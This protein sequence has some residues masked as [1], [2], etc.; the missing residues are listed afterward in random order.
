[1]FCLPRVEVCE[2]LL[3]RRMR[4]EVILREGSRLHFFLLQATETQVQP[5]S[6]IFSFAGN[7]TMNLAQFHNST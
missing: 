7:V 4:G 1:M 6:L 2:V 3:R 5:H